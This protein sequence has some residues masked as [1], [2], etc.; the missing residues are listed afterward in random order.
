MIVRNSNPCATVSPSF[1][2][3]PNPPPTYYL[4]GLMV[5]FQGERRYPRFTRWRRSRGFR[6]SGTC[7]SFIS[8]RL[9]GSGERWTWDRPW[10]R[11]VSV[12][13]SR[14][15]YCS[16]TLGFVCRT[17]GSMQKVLRSTVYNDVYVGP[18][19]FVSVFGLLRPKA[20]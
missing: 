3:P 18:A 6:T 4:P 14:G 5:Q 2:P 9:H 16:V 12:C 11:G 8:K 13:I 19:G 7:A 20:T 10:T 1:I 15:S 17:G